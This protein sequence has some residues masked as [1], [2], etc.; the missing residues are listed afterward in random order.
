M[1]FVVYDPLAGDMRGVLEGFHAVVGDT[2]F[3]IVGAGSGTGDMAETRPLSLQVAGDKVVG[4][5]IAVLALGGA[6]EVAGVG[7]SG[8][9]RLGGPYEVTGV[10]GTLL[11]GLDGQRALDVYMAVLGG[12]EQVS[13]ESAEGEAQEAQVLR[14]TPRGAPPGSHSILAPYSLDAETGA[15]AL[16]VTLS[17]GDRV[18]VVA[19]DHAAYRARLQDSLTAGLARLEGAPIGALVSDCFGYKVTLRSRVGE[20]LVPLAGVLRGAPIAGMYS[21]GEIGN[22]AGGEAPVSWFSNFLVSAAVLASR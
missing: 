3:P 20:E 17:P 21:G 8:C 1:L 15:I 16:A 10:A 14:V 4:G 7:A 22:V 12:S 18:E 19:I 11:T 13:R 6:L 9:R 2:G 5:S